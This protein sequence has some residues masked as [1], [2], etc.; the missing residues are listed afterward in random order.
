M[1]EYHYWTETDHPIW[2]IGGAENGV[3]SLGIEFTFPKKIWR[4]GKY[5]IVEPCSAT[6]ESWETYDGKDIARFDS[7]KE[8]QDYFDNL[9]P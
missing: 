6:F 4:K 1:T 9:T 2:G 7:L 5:S 3:H 8:A